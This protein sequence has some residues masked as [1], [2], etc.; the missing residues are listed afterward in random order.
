[1]MEDQVRAGRD[2]SDNAIRGYHINRAFGRG[3]QINW[4]P[5]SRHDYIVLKKKRTHQ[6]TIEKSRDERRNERAR[7]MWLELGEDRV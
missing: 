6:L 3:K 4:D 1:M 7:V 2:K 5:I